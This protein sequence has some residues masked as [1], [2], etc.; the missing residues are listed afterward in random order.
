MF[1]SRVGKVAVV[2]VEKLI[3]TVVRNFVTLNSKN[4]YI[5]AVI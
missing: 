2:V 4:K 3:I 1:M 5:F